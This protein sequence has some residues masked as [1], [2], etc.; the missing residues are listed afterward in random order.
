MNIFL[1]GGT[2]FIGSYVT[3]ELL[4]QNHKITILSRN[5]N[6]VPEFQKIKQLE[7][8]KGSLADTELLKKLIIGKDACI[9]IALNYSEQ[10]TGWEV[11]LD[12]TLPTVFMS[13]IAVKENVKHFIYTLLIMQ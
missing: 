3:L 11:L 12:D 13:N 10:K 8:V 5:P 2:G 4:K 7:V 6:K 1:T 9:H